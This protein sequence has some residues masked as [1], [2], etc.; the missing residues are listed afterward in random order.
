M[1]RSR[2]LAGAPPPSGDPPRSPAD[3]AAAA[4]LPAGAQ[5]SSG[6]VAAPLRPAVP[7]AD[8]DGDPESS[9]D[10]SLLR[11]GRDL[12]GAGFSGSSGA[13]RALPGEVAGHP[14]GFD[15]PELPGPGELLGSFSAP[16]RLRRSDGL[17]FPFKPK[18]SEHQEVFPINDPDRGEADATY[19]SCTWAQEVVNNCLTVYHSRNTLSKSE[20]DERLAWLA[21]ASRLHFRILAARYDYLAASKEEPGLAELYRCSDAVP[22]NRARWPRLPALPRERGQGRQPCPRQARR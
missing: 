12:G 1:R 18:D 3:G 10:D 4:A 13:P 2:R 17:P 19:Q 20:L 14:D 22:R 21:I 15:H 5:A 7:P 9:D 16:R 6:R 8:P 11:A